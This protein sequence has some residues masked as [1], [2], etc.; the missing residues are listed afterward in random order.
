MV[1]GYVL[2]PLLEENFRRAMLLS[3]GDISVYVTRPISAGIIGAC[4]LLIVAQLW[5]YAMRLR[6]PKA[7]A[8]PVE[9]LMVE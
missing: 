4:A 7:K 2:G 8:I 5:G 9:E 6:R 1:L 3:R